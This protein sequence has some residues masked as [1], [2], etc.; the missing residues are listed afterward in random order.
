[1]GKN[2]IRRVY[3]DTS[4]IGGQ[5]DKEFDWQTEPFWS[6]VRRRDI[7]I[8]VSD[9]LRGKMMGAP[10][11]VRAFFDDLLLLPVEYVQLTS[12]A[13][14]LAGK[15]ISE[16]VVGESC[17]D[18]A[19]HIAMAT[20]ARADVLVSWN[21]KHI[22]NVGRIRAYNSVHLRLGYLMIE[23]QNTSGGGGL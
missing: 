1:M 7:T 20:L 3:V 10:S 21:F 15:Y 14:D 9:I 12:E 13:G 17:L 18:D 2:M 6:A 4:V 8:I 23:N 22:V 19:R 5:F 11:H 16:K